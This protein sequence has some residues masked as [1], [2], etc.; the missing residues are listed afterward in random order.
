MRI[1]RIFLSEKG[2]E[3]KIE[4]L[5]NSDF[6]KPTSLVM[7]V[8]Y[9]QGGGC[10]T[11]MMVWAPDMEGM[12][13]VATRHYHV[14][15]LCVHDNFLY[16]AGYSNEIVETLHNKVISRRKHTVT[17][18]CVHNGVMYD[19][20]L[21]KIRRTDSGKQIA[22]REGWVKALC[23]S[24]GELYDAGS[25]NKVMKTFSNETVAERKEW[26]YALHSH[27]GTLYDS[28]SDC[29]IRNTI[30]NKVVSRRKD[31]P[32][33]LFSFEGK[34]YDAGMYYSIY[35]TLRFFKKKFLEIKK[36]GYNFESYRGITSIQPI[37]SWL[38]NQLLAKSNNQ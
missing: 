2:L 19:G 25:Y 12:I 30:K 35:E 13:K 14:E 34:L 7:A 11:D 20:S 6:Y 37:S 15:S 36:E 26:I 5:K 8:T 29:K 21:K 31:I 17:S 27:N 32:F 10:A 22:V 16:E 4:D 23:S 33:A 3:N 28:T 9:M 1:P 24:N 38:A 18:L